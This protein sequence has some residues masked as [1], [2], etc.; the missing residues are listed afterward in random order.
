MSNVDITEAVRRE[1]VAEINSNPDNREALEARYGQVWDTDQ[2]REEF[3]VTG[4]LAPFVSVMRRSD[5]QKGIMMFQHGPRY[6]YAFE[7]A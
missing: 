7:A 4:F 5:G 1:M 3:E 6:Y 2:L